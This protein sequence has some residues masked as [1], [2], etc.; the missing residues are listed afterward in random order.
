M[1]SQPP[2]PRDDPSVS[3]PLECPPLRWGLL[4]CGRV[5]HDFCQALKVLPSQKVVACAASEA[6]RA[7]AFAQKH[8]IE[9]AYGSYEDLVKDDQVQIIYVGT[10]HAFR[11]SMGELCLRANKHIL[12]EKPFCCT[13]EDTEYILNLAKER[14]LFVLEGIWTRFFPAF[15]MARRLTHGSDSILGQVVSVLSDFNFCASDSEDYPTSF[16][17][18]RKLGG[19][20]TYLVGTYPMTAVTAFYA[21]QM[22]ESIQV[23]GQVDPATGVDIQAALVLSY[24]P[25]STDCPARDPSDVTIPIPPNS[26]TAVLSYGFLTESPEE[27][28]VMGTRGRLTIAT[29][30]HCPTKLRVSCKAPGRGQ[31]A[32]QIEYEFALP[33]DTDAI[34]QAGGYNYPNSAGFAY[35]AAAVARCIAAGKTECEQ[36]TWDEIRLNARLMEKVR[37]QLKIQPAGVE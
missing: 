15:E 34:T 37:D 19:G 5:S 4:G 29:P 36:Y 14:N 6:D 1:S 22:P 9:N 24:A 11:R 33:A 30:G 10:V 12:M 31:V 17:F 21:Q 16:F 2:P 7:Q 25:T 18:N 26:G 8:G 32:E 28:T 13:V 20:A 35:E 23:V 27:T 3:D